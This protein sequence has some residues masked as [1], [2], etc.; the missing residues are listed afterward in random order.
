MTVTSPEQLERNRESKRR[1]AINKVRRNRAAFFEGKSCVKCGVTES[2]ELDHIDPEQ[3]TEHRIWTWS[4]ER[5]ESELAKCQ[6]LCTDCHK[7]KTSA[8]RAA[9]VKCGTEWAYRKGCRCEECRTAVSRIRRERRER[10]Q[11]NDR[12]RV[13][14][15]LR[16]KTA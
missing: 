10:K 13:A 12:D 2:L 15:L 6:V 8:E 11:L 3:K 14:R 7:E 9:R 1:H 16:R 5:R 4:P